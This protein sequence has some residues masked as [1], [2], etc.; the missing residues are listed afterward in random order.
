M[1]NIYIFVFYSMKKSCK[2]NSRDPKTIVGAGNCF[3]VMKQYSLKLGR[4]IG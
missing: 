4:T 1:Y 2:T 3:I